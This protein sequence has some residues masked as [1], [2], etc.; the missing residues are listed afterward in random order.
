MKERNFLADLK[1][2]KSNR[3]TEVRRAASRVNETYSAL[4]LT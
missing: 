3:V 2:A 1:D 4:A